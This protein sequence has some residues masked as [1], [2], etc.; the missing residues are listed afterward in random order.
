MPADVQRSADF[1]D[2]LARRTDGARVLRIGIG[3]FV[4]SNSEQD[5]IT[6]VALGSCV[7]VCL[8]EPEA[9]VAGM[10]H[11]MLPDSKLSS[12][13]AQVQPAAFADT[14]IPLL[15]RAAYNLGAQKKRCLVRLIGGAEL[16]GPKSPTLEGVFNVGPR[17]VLAARGVLWRNGI[18]THGESVGGGAA[19][20]VSL[21]VADGRVAVR[22]NGVVV[23]EL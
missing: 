13:R 12:E 16:G 19:R 7:A 5:V 3:E 2:P 4:V 23:A 17:N 11:F 1:A 9:K 14:G 21:P 6:T 20:S 22:I 10:L 18:M 15:F 8:W